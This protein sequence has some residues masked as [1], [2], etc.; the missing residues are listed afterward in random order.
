MTTKGWG[1]V[2]EAALTGFTQEGEGTSVGCLLTLP[3][4]ITINQANDGCY[5]DSK[6]CK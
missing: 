3:I 2:G 1:G 6:V 5:F 4:W